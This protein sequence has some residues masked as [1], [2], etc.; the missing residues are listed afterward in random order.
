MR[1][2]DASVSKFYDYT[3]EAGRGERGLRGCMACYFDDGMASLF[4]RFL[5]GHLFLTQNP[6]GVFT[7]LSIS[8]GVF[9]II[10]DGLERE[11]I[12]T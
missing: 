2:I 5:E 4:L 1:V 11:E 7:R 8:S 3:R 6:T 10:H 9:M 12:Q